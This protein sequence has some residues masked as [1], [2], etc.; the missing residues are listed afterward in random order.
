MLEIIGNKIGGMK[1]EVLLGG[2]FVLTFLFEPLQKF[3]EN[4]TYEIFSQGLTIIIQILVLATIIL[5]LKQQVKK[6]KNNG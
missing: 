1:E 3:M 2:V 5:K 4:I 6:N